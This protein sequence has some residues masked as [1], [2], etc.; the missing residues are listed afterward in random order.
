MEN[1]GSLNMVMKK[2]MKAT[3]STANTMDGERSKLT[4]RKEAMRASSLME[5]I[6]FGANSILTKT[7]IMKVNYSMGSPTEKAC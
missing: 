7:A 4:K 5:S 1:L 3:S 6:V 2:S